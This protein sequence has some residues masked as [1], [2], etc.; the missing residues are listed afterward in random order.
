MKR[1]EE[2]TSNRTTEEVG[3]GGTDRMLDVRGHG[4]GS[5]EVQADGG[6]F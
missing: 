6:M 4:R 3:L 2:S 5:V 1:E